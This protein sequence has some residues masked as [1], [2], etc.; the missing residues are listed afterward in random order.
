MAALVL[1]RLRSDMMDVYG[2]SSFPH[3]ILLENG[4]KAAKIEDETWWRPYWTDSEVKKAKFRQEK[5]DRTVDPYDSCTR[6][7]HDLCAKLNKTHRICDMA[8]SF[9][10]GPYH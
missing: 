7:V 6:A 2:S 1:W 4:P 3:L 10:R 8:V 9:D 5:S